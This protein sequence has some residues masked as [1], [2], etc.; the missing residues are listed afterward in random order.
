MQ[1]GGTIAGVGQ[2]MIEGAAKMMAAKFFSALEAQVKTHADVSD[3]D[4]T[5]Q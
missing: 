3:P 4:K 5:A 2:R 1:I